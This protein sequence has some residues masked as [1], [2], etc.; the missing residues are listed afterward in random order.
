[1]TD[2]RKTQCDRLLALLN[3]KALRT[4]EGEIIRKSDGSAYWDW[5][6]LPEIMQLGIAS[7]TRRIHELRKDWIIVKREEYVK[8]QRRTA[9]RLV[10]RKNP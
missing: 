5:A 6:A 8:G 1:M 2:K 7:H 10:G 4:L 3:S 9:Y